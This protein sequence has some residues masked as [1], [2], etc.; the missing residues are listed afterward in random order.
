MEGLD[1]RDA[2][3][4]LPHLGLLA[5]FPA[6]GPGGSLNVLGK[7]LVCV[8]C[9]STLTGLP[10]C[11][12]E[13]ASKR[14]SRAT[15]L[16]HRCSLWG[17]EPALQKPWARPGKPQSNHKVVSLWHQIGSLLPCGLRVTG[18]LWLSVRQSTYVCHP[19]SDCGLASAGRG[20]HC[21]WGL[22]MAVR[23]S[24]S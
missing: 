18:N 13:P 23:L 14:P 2:C 5:V 16:R 6:S 17:G 12:S 1:C 3:I 7:G 9:A 4:A 8:R 11:P 21:P 24:S 20:S 22:P 15:W 19:L 10:H